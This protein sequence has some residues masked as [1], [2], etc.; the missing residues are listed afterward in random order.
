MSQLS[1]RTEGQRGSLVVVGTGI[2][3]ISHLTI[4]SDAILRQADK[5][6]YL[7]AD[8][9]T[10]R[11]LLAANGT[12]ESLYRFYGSSKDRSETYEEMVDELMRAVQSGLDVCCA[13]YGHPSV[14]AYPGRE[15]VRRLKSMGYSARILPAISAEDCVF[16]DL[17]IDPGAVGCYSVEATDFLAR[18]RKFDP[19]S[20]LILWQVALVGVQTN[21]RE[22]VNRRGLQIL[23]ERLLAI[24]PPSHEVIIYQAAQFPIGNPRVDR[25][26][27]GLLPD[28]PMTPICTLVVPPLPNRTPDT[29]MAALLTRANA[30]VS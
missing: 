8:P 9:V 1:D 14:F 19:T 3:A 29:D 26:E 4:E 11:W 22:P 24:Y 15:A 6:F 13:F 12:A 16:A 21:P 23:S 18:A 28:A 25:L 2:K 20:L 27:L 10:E 17:G 7:V 30:T 5:L